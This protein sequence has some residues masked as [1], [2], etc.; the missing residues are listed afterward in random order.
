VLTSLVVRSSEAPNYTDRRKWPR[1]LAMFHQALVDALAA[2]GEV[3]P[4]FREADNSYLQVRAVNAEH[5]RAEFYATYPAKGDDEEQRQENRRRQFNRCLNKAQA[6]RL[7]G[8][9]RPERNHSS[10]APGDLC[11]SFFSTSRAA[12]ARH[13][14]DSAVEFVVGSRNGCPL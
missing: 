14:A 5:V 10:T 13:R 2:S 7:I 11:R 3:V 6:E 12:R 8:R 1:G 4:E 9:K